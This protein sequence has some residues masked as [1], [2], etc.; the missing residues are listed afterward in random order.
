MDVIRLALAIALLLLALAIA[1]SVAYL[2]PDPRPAVCIVDV[3]CVGWEPLPRGPKLVIRASND[4]TYSFDAP[5]G[6]AWSDAVW[7]DDST[8]AMATLWTGDQRGGSFL[9]VVR[10]DLPDDP[11][12]G[13]CSKRTVLSQGDVSARFTARSWVS[14]LESLSST[15]EKIIV[16]VGHT[17]PR[18]DGPGH[19][20]KHRA[21]IYDVSKKV[22]RSPLD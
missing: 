10:F 1:L 16:R 19:A 18:Y 13:E 14:Q 8:F 22:F 7:N 3:Q 4:R 6:Q 11:R 2:S 9:E 5:P 17:D 20:F 15:G 12:R 21:F